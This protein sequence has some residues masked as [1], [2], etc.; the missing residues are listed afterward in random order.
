MLLPTLLQA[1]LLATCCATP[2]GDQAPPSLTT[3]TFQ[4]DPVPAWLLS[5][6]YA[7]TEIAGPADPWHELSVSVAHRFD[8]AALEVSARYVDR[9][10]ATDAGLGF[11]LHVPLWQGGYTNVRLQAAPDATVIPRF[12]AALELF[13]VLAPAWEASA[14]V[15]QDRFPD[16][17]VDIYGVSLAHFA[18]PWAVRGRINAATVGG[19]W[20]AF[21][22]GQLRRTL[23][24]R[25]SFLEVAAGGGR[26]V[27]E[28]L[29]PG[30][31][32]RVQPDIRT[33]ATGNAAVQLMAARHLGA[34]VGLG[35]SHY[36]GLRD[37]VHGSV[38]VVVRW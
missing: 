28:I 3:P 25:D 16:A 31:P 8:R 30:P 7:R 19:D 22:S 34:R 26:E 27:V 18:G 32:D 33:A 9:G 14:L 37:R 24:D 23:G 20:A 10:V 4:P 29:V 21:G 12:G 36:D 5:L 6:G 2:V 15:R 35:Y 11:D 17:S 13:Q 1:L 38:S